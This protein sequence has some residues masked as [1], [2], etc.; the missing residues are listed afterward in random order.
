MAFLINTLL[1]SDGN[2]TDF[3]LS[4]VL[5]D[6]F[7][8][9]RIK[10]LSQPGHDPNTAKDFIRPEGDPTPSFSNTQK[11]S[12]LLK[13]KEQSG[14]EPILQ[15]FRKYTDAKELAE[16]TSYFSGGRDGNGFNR[17]TR[18]GLG[19]PSVQGLR[20]KEITFYTPTTNWS[21]SR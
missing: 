17:E 3:K 4:T 5:R 14:T 16:S 13:N 6:D 8:M 1:R 7:T 10:L 19:N 2:N 18:I 15:D 20:S 12:Q 21:L 9:G 11:Y